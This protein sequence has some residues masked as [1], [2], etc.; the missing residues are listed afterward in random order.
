MRA[1]FLRSGSRSFADHE[2]LE[3]LLFYSIPRENTNELAHDLIER[4]GSIHRLAAASPEELMLVRGVGENTAVLIKLVL[5]LAQRCSLEEIGSPKRFDTLQKA[6]DLS[7]SLFIGATNE[8]MYLLLLDNSFCFIDCVCVAYG[9]INEI[10]PIMRT[11]IERSIVKKASSVII[12][13][14]HPNGTE[15]TSEEDERFTRLVAQEL[16]IVGIDLLEHI[17]MSKKGVNLI[18][19]A[20]R[21]ESELSALSKF[22]NEY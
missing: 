11:V 15:D 21:S 17:V 5:A 16:D 2:L 18:M 7:R 20:T 19:K 3:L 14:N 6:V 8:T 22:Y 1:R 10:R 13:H 12:L 9:S 4:F